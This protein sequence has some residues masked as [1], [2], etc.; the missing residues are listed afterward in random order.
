MDP[1]EIEQLIANAAEYGQQTLAQQ[2]QQAVTTAQL[3]TQLQDN[4]S[5]QHQQQLDH[6]SGTA[7]VAQT[8]ANQNPLPGQSTS[9]K[10]AKPKT[11]TGKRSDDVAN[12]IFSMRNLFAVQTLT[13]TE[14]LVH[15]S[16]FRGGA[17]LVAGSS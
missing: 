16:S 2:V 6:A 1:V 15:A 9:L 11:F 12:W 14:K 13:E 17:I 10:L 4:N 3:Q 7:E 5:D 8:Q